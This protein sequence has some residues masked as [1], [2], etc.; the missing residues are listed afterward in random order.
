VQDD[1][2]DEPSAN[3]DADPKEFTADAGADLPIAVHPA[4]QYLT[5]W[6]VAA[7]NPARLSIP[8]TSVLFWLL[9]EHREFWKFRKVRQTYLLKHLY[10][11]EL[12]GR[13]Q[14]CA[15]MCFRVYPQFSLLPR[16]FLSCQNHTFESCLLISAKWQGVVVRYGVVFTLRIRHTTI[17]Y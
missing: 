1:T 8:S 3:L 12:V 7:G 5:E 17:G 4:L 11:R 16:S 14:F 9:Q 10:N 13:R 15:S 2:K 6:Q